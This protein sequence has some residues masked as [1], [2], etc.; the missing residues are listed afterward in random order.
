[1]LTRSQLFAVLCVLATSSSAIAKPISLLQQ[2]Q[3]QH[4][5]A[6]SLESGGSEETSAAAS[7]HVHVFSSAAA[8]A[9]ADA[10]IPAEVLAV[11]PDASKG[12]EAVSAWDPAQALLEH[13]ALVSSA[14]I[15]N[16][17]DSQQDA[18][19]AVEALRQRLSEP[20]LLWLP[21]LGPE[22]DAVAVAAAE[23]STGSVRWMTEGDKLR[24]RKE[25]RWFVDVTE[26]GSREKKR[27]DELSEAMMAGKA[28]ECC[29]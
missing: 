12:K 15:Q 13:A 24:L 26:A 3:P 8:Q 25:G 11:L 22:D 28:S 20:K 2:Q 19:D 9:A 5:V 17:H 23:S 29:R 1:M 27:Q 6:F 7:S 21:E 18:E 4:Q 16:V 10:R 14:A